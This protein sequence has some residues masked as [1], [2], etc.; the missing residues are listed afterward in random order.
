ML[1][2]TDRQLTPVLTVGKSS[3]I[4]NRTQQ[5][6]NHNNNWQGEKY[7]MVL[8]PAKIKPACPKTDDQVIYQSFE[9]GTYWA[10][11]SRDIAGLKCHD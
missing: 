2:H 11:N 5:V 3:T 1:I 10:K 9:T 6:K 7:R 4:K 8:K